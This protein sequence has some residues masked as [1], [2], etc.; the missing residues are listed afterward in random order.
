VQWGLVAATHQDTQHG[1]FIGG[2]LV[3]GRSL[4]TQPAIAEADGCELAD[5]ALLPDDQQPAAFAQYYP[6]GVA[7]FMDEVEASVSQLRTQY[8][9]RVF[10]FSMNLQGERAD[11]D[12]YSPYAERLDRIGDATDSLFVISAGNLDSPAS[13]VAQRSGGSAAYARIRARGLL[14]HSRGEYSQR[15]C[16]GD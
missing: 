1:T 13:R 2:L 8:G 7:D 9:I 11:P 5:L 10:N 12:F 16:G 6:N 4:N 14:A 3:A 15:F